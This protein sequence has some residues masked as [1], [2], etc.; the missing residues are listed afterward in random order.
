MANRGKAAVAV[1]TSEFELLARTMADNAGRPGLRVLVLPYPL[2][3]KPEEEVRAVGR[4][5]YRSL[6]R[7][8]GVPD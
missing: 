8:V 1:V 2:D 7:T 6:L 4:A 3:T 5:H